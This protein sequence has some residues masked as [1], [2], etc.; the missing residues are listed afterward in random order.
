MVAGELR[1]FEHRFPLAPGSWSDGDDAEVVHD[2]QH[3]QLV[4]YSRGNSEINYRRFFAITTLAGVRVEDPEVFSATH[5]LI[6]D[7]CAAVARA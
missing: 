1:Y 5:A 3:Y 7:W 4:D 6:R 2:R